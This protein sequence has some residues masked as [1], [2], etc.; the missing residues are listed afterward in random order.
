MTAEPTTT[1]PAGDVKPEDP[2][3]YYDPA[4]HTDPEQVVYVQLFSTSGAV[5]RQRDPV[6][7]V[8]P[9]VRAFIARETAA[10]HGPAS[11]ADCIAERERRRYAAFVMQGIGDQYAPK[12]HPNLNTECTKPRPWPAFPGEGA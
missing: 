4:V 7:L 5:W 12:E 6:H 1:A 3:P 8:E 2:A 10:G 9:Y 11:K